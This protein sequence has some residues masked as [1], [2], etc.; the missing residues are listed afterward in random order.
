MSQCVI[1][2]QTMDFGK[3]L[4]HLNHLM[5]LD[6]KHLYLHPKLYSDKII[7]MFVKALAK[8]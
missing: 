5:I 4:T 1:S 7:I 3:S 8:F 2:Y 6:L